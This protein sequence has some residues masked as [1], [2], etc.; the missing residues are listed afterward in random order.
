MP[1]FG[2]L[3]QQ[4][5]GDMPP[6]KIQALAQQFLKLLM[7]QGAPAGIHGMVVVV[8]DVVVVVVVEVLVVVVVDVVVVVVEVLVVVVVVVVLVVV[9]VAAAFNDGTH[10]SRR[11]ISVTPSGPN[12]LLMCAVIVPN[13]ELAFDL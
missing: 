8:V 10:S 9:V 11:W 5:P 4:W 13:A 12:W 6:G 3:A 2:F 1:P 7:S